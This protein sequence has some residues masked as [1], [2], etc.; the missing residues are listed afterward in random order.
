MNLT[1]TEFSQSAEK[2]I[3]KNSM[4]SLNLRTGKGKARPVTGRMGPEGGVEV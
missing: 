1:S 2:F 3:L 4:Y